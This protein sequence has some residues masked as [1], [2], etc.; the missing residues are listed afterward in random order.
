MRRSIFFL[1]NE[2]KCFEISVTKSLVTI[3]I[4]F[5]AYSF[6]I[7]GI[8]LHFACSIVDCFSQLFYNFVVFSLY[9]WPPGG[10]GREH[11]AT[12]ISDVV[13]SAILYQGKKAERNC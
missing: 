10:A 5:Y 7:C 13:L 12:S 6:I 3:M 8:I 4:L 11:L 1:T 2:N 9:G